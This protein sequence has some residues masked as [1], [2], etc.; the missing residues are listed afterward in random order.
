MADETSLGKNLTRREAMKTALKAGAYAAPVIIAASVPRPV[1]AQTTGPTGTL[2]G[3]ISNAANGNPIFGA[4][5]DVAGVTATTNASG[6]YTIPNAPAGTRTVTVSATGF[7]SRADVINIAAG[8]T[9]N[10]STAL[11]A[12]TASGNITIVLTWGAQP[13]D[14][15]SHLMGPDGSSGRFHCYY[16]A[17]NPVPHAS[18][19][20]DDVT[21]F[22]PETITVSPVSGVFVAGSYEYGVYNFSGTPA[23]DVS[24]ANVGVFQGGVQLAQFP[25]SA[26]TGTGRW[27]RVFNFTLQA[28]ANGS[29]AITPVQS[30]GSTAPAD[31]AVMVAKS[32]PR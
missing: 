1:A 27:W 24:A 16:A 6:V 14:L 20:V 26:A 29:I 2:T 32:G 11:V 17:Q 12:I 4:T 28:T 13:S 23:F 3:T 31:A 22:G 19:D 7:T 18:L 21:A 30:I 10:Y 15:D 5:V 25:V 9:T 8:A